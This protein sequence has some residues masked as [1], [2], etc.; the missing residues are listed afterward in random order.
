MPADTQNNSSRPKLQQPA[1]C[2]KAG[3]IPSVLCFAASDPTCG[4]GLQADVITIAALGTRPLAVTTAI[5]VQNS[6]TFEG[7]QS[8]DS[9][10][11]ADQARA[12]LEDIPVQAFKIGALGS[13]ANIEAVAEILSDYPDIP[14]VLDPALPTSNEDPMIEEEFFGALTELLLPMSRVLISD[15]PDA[16]RLTSFEDEEEEDEPPQEEEDQPEGAECARRLIQLGCEHVLIT[17]RH[18]QTPK[19]LNT[20]YGEHGVIRTDAWERLPSAF[21]GAGNALSAALASFL[22]HGLPVFEAAY[23]AQEYTW[24]ALAQGRRPGMGKTLPKLFPIF[25]AD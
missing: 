2:Q 8:V 7:L 6:S 9:D 1:S 17:G 23:R 15:L 24:H 19:I 25:K 5:T 22:A 4:A 16:Q 11:V 14:V 12:L 3:I 21:H 18:E 13:V 10:W 20:L